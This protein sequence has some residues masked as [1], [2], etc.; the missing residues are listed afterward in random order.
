MLKESQG[1]KRRRAP[2]IESGFDNLS[3]A[4]DLLANMIVRRCMA[5]ESKRQTAEKNRTSGLG[6]DQEAEPRREGNG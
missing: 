1:A 2:S 5:T 3:Y 4:L 6:H